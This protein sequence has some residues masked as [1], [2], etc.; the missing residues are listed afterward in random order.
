MRKV[1]IVAVGFALLVV[2]EA[3]RAVPP[4]DLSDGLFGYWN[5]ESG[6]DDA[7]G[8]G[9]NGVAVGGATTTTA[10]ARNGR[11][12]IF[13]GSFDYVELGNIWPGGNTDITLAAWVRTDVV[14][15]SANG[16]GG[17]IGLGTL[18]VGDTDPR[19]HLY[20]RSVG[21]SDSRF[22]GYDGDVHV[23][24]G[25]DDGPTDQWWATDAVVTPLTWYHVVVTYSSLSRELSIYLDGALDRSVILSD[26][27]DLGTGVR[28]G[29]DHYEDNWMQGLIDDAAI[30]TRVLDSDEVAALYALDGVVPVGD[31]GKPKPGDL[32][33]IPPGTLQNQKALRKNPN[34]GTAILVAPPK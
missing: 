26:T 2:V 7:S 3:A 31:G 14:G 5:M 27:L 33:Y 32:I 1:R 34:A 20:I 11:S 17:H 13:D 4:P 22:D 12:A 25:A 6:F 10:N 16:A 23:S 15:S 29:V 9:R 28:I 21:P 30:W 19:G 24:V 18:A 8:N